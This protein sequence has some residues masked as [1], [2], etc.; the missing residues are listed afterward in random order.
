[1]RA[2]VPQPLPRRG[3]AWSEESARERE[4]GE[5]RVRSARRRFGCARSD[6]RN[7]REECGRVAT[8]VAGLR[9]G[10]RARVAR[11]AERRSARDGDR[12]SECATRASSRVAYLRFG[13]RRGRR[14]VPGRLGVE[15]L[16][17]ALDEHRLEAFGVQVALLE[18]LAEHRDGHRAR[19]G[20]DARLSFSCGRATASAGGIAARAFF[21]PTET[22][23]RVRE[24]RDAPGNPATRY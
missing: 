2:R 21:A 16:L 5:R 9:D 17:Q 8:G 10:S 6:R 4:W 15:R 14:F 11:T 1:M 19:L 24:A 3:P 12:S 20:H 23:P 13:R 7:R 18:L 22:R